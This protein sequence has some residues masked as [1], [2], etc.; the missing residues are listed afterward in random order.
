M[1]KSKVIRKGFYR[2][3]VKNTVTEEL[4]EVSGYTFQQVC[5]F[6]KWNIHD[7]IGIQLYPSKE[8]LPLKWYEPHT[9]ILYDREK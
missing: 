5:S 1:A 4:V 6:L 7:C 9:S 8:F 2:W 3:R